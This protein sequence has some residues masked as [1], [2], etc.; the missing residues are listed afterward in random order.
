MSSQFENLCSEG[1]LRINVESETAAQNVNDTETDFAG[2]LAEFYRLLNDYAPRW[3]SERHYQR[4][5]DVLRRLGR[6]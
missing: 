1:S 2:A 3:Y 6:L 5:Q 4:T